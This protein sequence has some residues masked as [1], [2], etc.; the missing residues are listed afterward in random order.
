MIQPD[1]IAASV[2][3]VFDRARRNA[4]VAVHAFFFID[5]NDRRE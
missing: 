5:P 1:D 2:V 4:G 3:A